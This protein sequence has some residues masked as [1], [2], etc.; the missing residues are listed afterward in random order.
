MLQ[1]KKLL[2]FISFLF[3]INLSFGQQKTLDVRHIN[4]DEYPKISADLWVRNPDGINQDAIKLYEETSENP[5]KINF[6]KKEIVK[7]SVA[8]NKCIVFLILNPGNYGNAELTWYKNV[9]KQAIRKGAIKKGD[10]VEVLNFNN[11]SSSQL[12]YPSTISFTDDTTAIFKKLESILLRDALCLCSGIKNK[13]LIYQAINQTLDQIEKQN[14]NIPAGIFVL[15]DDRACVAGSTGETPGIR[16]KRLN[17]PIFGINYYKPDQQN[18]IKTFCEESFGLYYSDPS[19]NVANASTKLNSYLN[20]FLQRQ[21]GFYYSLN[22][23]TT[24]EKD[25]KSHAVKVDAKSDNTA[26][27]LPSPNKNIIEWVVANPILA[28][29]IFLLLGVSIFL[30]MR[31]IKNEKAKKEA[32][33]KLQAQQMSDIDKQHRENEQLMSAKLSAQQQELEGIKRKEQQ[34]RDAEQRKK[35]D[36]ENQNRDKELAAQML[37]AGNYPWFD[38][39]MGNNTKHRFEIRTPQIIVGRAENCNL[40]IDNPTVSKNHFQLNFKSNGEYWVK[41]LG[42]SN[43]LYVNGQKVQQTLLKHGDFIQ[44]GE[45]VL[46]FFI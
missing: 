39:T 20:S 25:G 15:A 18:S 4:T 44:A 19:M 21:A 38:Y 11:E 26:F 32:E 16:S 43:G 33:R 10:K 24:Y 28:A 9:V 7:D 41:D 31:M 45:M 40:R 1:L 17:V 42:S 27:L 29:I 3:V 37:L 8:K 14:F 35:V 2:F 6:T 36:Q 5:I 23:N 46:N 12:L 30:T 34:Q 13:S 22:Y